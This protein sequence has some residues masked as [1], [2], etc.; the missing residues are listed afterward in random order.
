MKA[1]ESCCILGKSRFFVKILLFSKI[2]QNS[3]NNLANVLF[4]IS[5]TFGNFQQKLRLEN[6]IFCRFLHN[7]HTLFFCVIAH[8]LPS[9]FGK[10][11]KIY[12]A[13]S[14]LASPSGR[15]GPLRP[16]LS[17]DVASVVPPQLATAAPALGLRLGTRRL[18]PPQCTCSLRC[19][20]APLGGVQGLFYRKETIQRPRTNANGTKR[21]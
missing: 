14:P 6:G 2:L 11:F 18:F 8:H 17:C 10:P 1:P 7:F 21:N 5:K 3:D 13:R 16:F 19:A 4:K 12:V 9:P 20:R 15:L